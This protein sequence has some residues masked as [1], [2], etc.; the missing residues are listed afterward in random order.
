MDPQADGDNPDNLTP[1]KRLSPTKGAGPSGKNACSP[2][3][4]QFG[5][6]DDSPARYANSKKRDEKSSEKQLR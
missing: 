1:Q 2:E 6:R 5:A 3:G 4:L